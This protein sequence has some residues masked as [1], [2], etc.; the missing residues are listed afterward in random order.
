MNKDAIDTKLSFYPISRTK[1]LLSQCPLKMANKGNLEKFVIFRIS[2]LGSVTIPKSD[3]VEIRDKYRLTTMDLNTA[4]GAEKH[5]SAVPYEKMRMKKVL[6]TIETYKQSKNKDDEESKN[7]LLEIGWWAHLQ[8]KDEVS[9]LKSEYYLDF[10]ENWLS[11][12]F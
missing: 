10:L 5:Y 3:M 7:N 12:S 1:S 8:A 4:R 11:D 9:F 2:S 6:S